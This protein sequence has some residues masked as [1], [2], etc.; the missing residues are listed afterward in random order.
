MR[1][2]L[3]TV[4]AV[5]ALVSCTKDDKPTPA[6]VTSVDFLVSGTSVGA[7]DL[8]SFETGARVAN[9][10]SISTKWDFGM[11]FEKI[12]VNSNASGPGSAGVQVL[13]GT[14]ESVLEAPTTGYA[15]DTTGTQLAVKGPQWYIYN[16]TTRT[17]APIAGKTFVFKTARNT[18]AKMEI[19]S[20]DPADDNGNLVVP[21]TRPTK[22]KYKIRFAHQT[23][24]SRTF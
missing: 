6:V 12:I 16:S 5:A 15:Y 10:D 7:H 1:S 9:T 17:F 2:I 4:F 13:N 11:R 23:S 21:P 14:F 24:G 22:I 8:F 20:A 3:M 18:Y 19:L